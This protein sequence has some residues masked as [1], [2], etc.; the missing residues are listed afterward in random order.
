MKVRVTEES[1][2]MYFQFG[3]KII[4]DVASIASLTKEELEKEYKDVQSKRNRIY[5]IEDYYTDENGV[6]YPAI[7]IGDGKAYIADLPT[8]TSG[9]SGSTEELVK[10]INDNIRH[11]TQEERTTWN[12]KITVTQ[13]GETLHFIY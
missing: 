2:N 1:P 10:H 4:R 7:K 9:S 13:D 6:N 12:Q 11:I 5:V 8:V 3:D